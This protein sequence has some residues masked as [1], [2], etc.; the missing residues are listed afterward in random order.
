MEVIEARNRLFK[1]LLASL[2]D[3]AARE[4]SFDL[5]KARFESF[6]CEFPRNESVWLR[7]IDW[8]LSEGAKNEDV[9]LVFETALDR[10]RKSTLLWYKYV[11]HQPG[12]EDA[13]PLVSKFEEAMDAVGGDWNADKFHALIFDAIAD[14]RI[15][16]NEELVG[17]IAKAVTKG[18]SRLEGQFESLRSRLAVG[19]AAGSINKFID[20]CVSQVREKAS[21]FGLKRKF[22]IDL[23]T[24]DHYRSYI[25]AL[26]VD[27]PTEVEAVYQRMVMKHNDDQSAWVAYC[28]WL[29][30]NNRLDDACAVMTKACRV[31]APWNYWLKLSAGRMY[32]SLGLVEEAAAVYQQTAD[33]CW[34]D[35]GTI[36]ELLSVVPDNRIPILTN[37]INRFGNDPN[38]NFLRILLSRELADSGA[39]ESEQV[40]VLSAIVSSTLQ[41]HKLSENE[42]IMFCYALVQ[43][44][45]MDAVEVDNAKIKQLLL[46]HY[47][48]IRQHFNKSLFSILFPTDAE[49]RPPPPKPVGAAP[50][51]A[52]GQVHH[53]RA[54][55]KRAL[56]GYTSGAL[57]GQYA[58]KH[59]L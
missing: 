57:A 58:Q 6:L 10:C 52:S 29:V 13:E 34:L 44:H 20:S 21:L 12:R 23:S 9:D 50:Q 48:T 42:K 45:R 1:S 51:R 38:V 32:T 24:M 36:N 14:S 33:T 19:K 49:G 5:K 53:Q 41:P 26:S 3:D 2:S 15:P 17:S 39:D 59:S 55:V 22:E 27:A 47:D 35:L 11:T 16:F 43:L 4:L 25:D 30:R 8:L 28:D 37:L 18:Y 54:N 56:P 7:F 46:S 31:F 40:A